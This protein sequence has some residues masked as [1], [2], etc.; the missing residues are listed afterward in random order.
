[1]HRTWEAVALLVVSAML[2]RAETQKPKILFP[3]Q[4]SYLKK[5]EKEAEEIWSK[6]TLREWRQ[7]LPNREVFCR[8]LLLDKEQQFFQ[9]IL[10]FAQDEDNEWG[11]RSEAIELLLRAPHVTLIE[12]LVKIAEQ[13][14]RKIQ[15]N[16]SW[17]DKYGVHAHWRPQE[18]ALEVLASIAEPRVVDILF[19]FAQQ[20][21]NPKVRGTIMEWTFRLKA[22]T[23]F[24]QLVG[25][26][27][28]S[29]GAWATGIEEEG[30]LRQKLQAKFDGLVEEAKRWWAENKGK[31]KI[32]WEWGVIP[33]EALHMPPSFPKE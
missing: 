31:V 2:L 28:W 27:D 6:E 7:R 13:I 19:E 25:R 26:W 18:A 32:R 20:H 4:G 24:A 23:R 29:W 8:R 21:P 33:V 12:P 22:F 10:E 1:M 3:L 5:L 14:P 11:Y 17:M 16:P 30:E 9:K 15:K